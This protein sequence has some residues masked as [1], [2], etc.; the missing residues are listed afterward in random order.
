M[1]SNERKLY[2]HKFINLIIKP[3]VILITAILLIAIISL[4]VYKIN[5]KTG[6]NVNVYIEG[7]LVETLSL[8]KDLKYEVN[9]ELGYNVIIVE[10]KKVYVEV[11]DCPDKICTKYEPICKTG[12]TIVCLPHKLVIEVR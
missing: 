11:A 12:E 4:V 9:N 3:D 8:D 1:K 7:E 2:L 5:Q 10:D 6:L